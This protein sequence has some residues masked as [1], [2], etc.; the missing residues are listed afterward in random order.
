MEGIKCIDEANKKVLKGSWQKEL[1]QI[2]QR[3]ED[4]LP[5]HEKMQKM[6]HTLQSLEDKLAQSKQNQIRLGGLNRPDLRLGGRLKM[7]HRTRRN[8]E[9]REL[10]AG[11]GRRGSNALHST[12]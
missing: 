7:P 11:E 12:K 9:I 10:R 5:G 2:E 6:S 8:V 1:A 3:R 4:L